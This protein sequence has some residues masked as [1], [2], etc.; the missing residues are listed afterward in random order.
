MIFKDYAAFNF[1]LNL[2]DAGHSTECLS[3]LSALLGKLTAVNS[4]LLPEFY[5]GVP[6]IIKYQT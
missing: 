4:V 1:Q 5:I 3:H 2:M 6:S